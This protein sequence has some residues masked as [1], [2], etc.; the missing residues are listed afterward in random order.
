MIEKWA[1]RNKIFLSFPPM[2]N[3]IDNDV[4]N[5]QQSDSIRKM[6]MGMNIKINKKKNARKKR[7]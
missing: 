7:M 1:N 4:E 5:E 6:R 3:I 2:K